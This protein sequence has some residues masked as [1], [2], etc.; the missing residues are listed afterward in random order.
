MKI[1]NSINQQYSY[2]GSINKKSEA[3]L[4]A[5]DI[6]DAYT[7]RNID[8]SEKLSQALNTLYAV[9]M[10]FTMLAMSVYNTKKM[11]LSKI[12][13][14]SV[15][16]GVIIGSL[17]SFQRNSNEQKAFTL[18]QNE[19]LSKV[20]SDKKS[21]IVPN[22]EQKKY[23][24][25]NTLDSRDAIHR[26][27][28]FEYNRFW[29]VNEYKETLEHLK[30]SDKYAIKNFYATK[31]VMSAKLDNGDAK[32][33]TDI[34]KNVEDKTNKYTND[35]TKD[36]YLSGALLTS[37]FA[38]ATI[39][40]FKK[41]KNIR[42]RELMCLIPFI[43]VFTTIRLSDC[44]FNNDAERIARYKTKMDI[45]RN[46]ISEQKTGYKPF[47][48]ISDYLKNRDFLRDKMLENEEVAFSKK[49]AKS[50]LEYND[51]QIDNAESLQKSFFTAIKNNTKI[52]EKHIR[53]K[54]ISRDLLINSSSLFLCGL[55]LADQK[56]AAK[57]K[58]GLFMSSILFV[59]TC[60]ANLGLIHIL[61][62]KQQ[63]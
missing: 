39:P 54:N 10:F 25:K 17:M 6:T 4:D 48:T 61:N 38:A 23:I 60:I 37:L 13:K 41:V 30:E 2:K 15:P 16:L 28:D 44:A 40:L 50:R 51:E 59:T 22:N 12:T 19:A 57:N 11:S 43:P 33:T 34:I 3:I 47:K 7:Q 53:N 8:K 27:A 20:L 52:R 24:D 32:F 14:F 42:L 49:I 31:D 26:D 5:M 58:K 29:S 21:F 45:R 35:F 55:L 36:V 56:N 46:G 9:P 18:G 62:K 1:V 63:T